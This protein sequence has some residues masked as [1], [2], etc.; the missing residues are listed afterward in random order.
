MCRQSSEG[1]GEL[2]AFAWFAL[3]PVFG[4]LKGSKGDLLATPLHRLSTRFF[5]AYGLYQASSVPT[6]F[7]C[8]SL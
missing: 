2:V 7:K 1:L 3:D 8:P 5:A 6:C 4:E